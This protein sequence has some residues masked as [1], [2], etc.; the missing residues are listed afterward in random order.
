MPRDQEMLR[1]CQKQEEHVKN[2]NNVYDI[3]RRMSQDVQ[4]RD[5]G[6]KLLKYL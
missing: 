6:V 4:Y 5:K 1:I 3:Q 2:D